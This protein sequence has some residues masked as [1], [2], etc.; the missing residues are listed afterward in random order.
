MRRF[1]QLMRRKGARWQSGATTP[2]ID[3]L[4]PFAGGDTI[5][6]DGTNTNAETVAKADVGRRFYTYGFDVTVIDADGWTGTTAR[7][8]FTVEDGTFTFGRQGTAKQFRLRLDGNNYTFTLATQ[9]SASAELRFV[10]DF[11]AGTITVYVDETEDASSP[12]TIGGAA[13]NKWFNAYEDVFVG[14]NHL[15]NEPWNGDISRP[16]ALGA[17]PMNAGNQL[18]LLIGQSNAEGEPQAS[19]TDTTLLNAYA[20]CRFYHRINGVTPISEWTMG[21]LDNPDTDTDNLGIELTFGRELDSDSG[22]TQVGVVKCTQGGTGFEQGSGGWASTAE[23]GPGANLVILKQT[24]WNAH[25]AMTQ[26]YGAAAGWGGVIISI[27]ETDALDSADAADY[28]T[29]LTAFIAELRS[30]VC[31]VADLPVYIVETA[32]TDA[33]WPHAGTVRTGQASV[34]AADPNVHLLETEGVVDYPL[35]ADNVHFTADALMELGTDLEAL[36]VTN[37][38][39]A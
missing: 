3:Y 5:T 6:L 27:G 36:A 15:G 34:A 22:A 35:R 4:M 29:Q 9:Y 13:A 8:I 38:D 12:F 32:T 21:D 11:R 39:I 23:G 16:I 18:W 14:Q 33:S 30:S 25:A 28:A 2:S 7:K 19:P 31:E 26:D 17:D 24:A 10:V 37:G 20:G 1:P